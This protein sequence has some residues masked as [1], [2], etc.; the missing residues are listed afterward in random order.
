MS[1]SCCYSTL[2]RNGSDVQNFLLGMI[3]VPVALKRYF[4]IKAPATKYEINPKGRI[5]L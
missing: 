1:N 5:L 4:I 3:S 2:M